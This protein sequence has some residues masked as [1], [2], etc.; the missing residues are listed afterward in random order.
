MKSFWHVDYTI[1]NKKIFKKAVEEKKILILLQ[2]LYF[3]R[4]IPCPPSDGTFRGSGTGSGVLTLIGSL[5][6]IFAF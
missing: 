2:S 6:K 1:Y 3:L 5:A 4:G